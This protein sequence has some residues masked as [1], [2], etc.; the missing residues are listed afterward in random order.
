MMRY[1]TSSISIVTSRKRVEIQ[2]TS[3]MTPYFIMTSVINCLLHT[4]LAQ[5][6]ALFHQVFQ[7]FQPLKTRLFNTCAPCSVNIRCEIN[8]LISHATR[9]RKMYRERGKYVINIL[10][11]EISIE[12]PSVGRLSLKVVAMC[13]PQI[14]SGGDC[15]QVLG[16]GHIL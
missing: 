11:R 15:F 4:L 16:N 1:F 13:P 12:H 14:R 9:H 10:S 6:N 5:L 3:E 2:S 7:L 8:G